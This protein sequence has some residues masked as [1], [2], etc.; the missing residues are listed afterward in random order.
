MSKCKKAVLIFLAIAVALGGYLSVTLTVFSPPQ[1]TLISP[2]QTEFFIEKRGDNTLCYHASQKPMAFV[3]SEFRLLVWNIHKGLDSGWQSQL[4]QFSH[5][6]DLLLLQE[7]SSQQ[8]LPSLL[9]NDFPYFLYAA[10]FSYRDHFSGVGTFSKLAAQTYCASATKEP[11]IQIPKVGTVTQYPLTNGRSLLVV[12]LHL[13][14]FEWNPT[15]YRQQLTEAFHFIEAHQ[16]PVILAGDFNTW[17][18]KRLQLVEELADT[19]QFKAVSF[20]PDVRFRF[21]G[22]PLDHVFIRGLSILQATT[23]ETKSSDHN[24]LLIRLK[25]E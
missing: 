5:D 3:Q 19:A 2:H 1:V 9:G 6:A 13:V 11:W 25:L 4:T 20:E 7:V 10:S 17:N 18:R 21:M 16:G 12:N 23:V 22:N 8:K 15:H 24:P 14:N